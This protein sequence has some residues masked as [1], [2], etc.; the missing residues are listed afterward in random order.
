[1]D[2]DASSTLAITIFGTNDAPVANP[3]TNWFSTDER[4]RPDV[5]RECSADV[6]HPGIR[7]DVDVCDVADTMLTLKT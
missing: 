2:D 7:L 6:A 1:M 4:S 3:D 5:E